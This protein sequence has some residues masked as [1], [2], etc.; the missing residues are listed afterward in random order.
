MDQ[1]SL[2]YAS[3]DTCPVLEK[4]PVV[5]IDPEDREAVL[6]LMNTFWQQRGPGASASMFGADEMQGALREFATPKPLTCSAAL[7]IRGE[8]FG[9]VEPEDHEGVHRNPEAEAVWGV[10][11]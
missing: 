10:T 5:V 1:A 11:E 4:R 8:H 6:T 3:Q 9:C 2:T 7:N